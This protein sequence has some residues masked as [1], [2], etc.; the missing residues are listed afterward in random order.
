MLQ[1]YIAIMSAICDYIFM[2]IS[3]IFQTKTAALA[4]LDLALNRSRVKGY[5]LTL[6]G[7]VWS[8]SIVLR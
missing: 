4:A 7:G 8:L 6:V 2:S 3:K 1:L 5:S